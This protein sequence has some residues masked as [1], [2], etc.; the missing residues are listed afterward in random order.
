MRVVRPTLACV[1]AMIGAMALAALLPCAMVAR[2]ARAQTLNLG[3]VPDGPT[4]PEECAASTLA[5]S[6]E[7][8]VRALLA[9]ADPLQGEARAGASAR[10]KVRS[11]A[12]LLLRSGS[13]K[14]WDE[15]APAVAGARLSLLIG[16]VD[17]L[18]DAAVAGRDRR[19]DPL[20]PADARRAIALLTA[21]GAA[22]NEP[23]R[24]AM[25]APAD[26][27]PTEVARALS[28]TLAPLVELAALLEGRQN[29]DPWPVLIDARAAQPDR[30]A[31]TRSSE[32]LR[33]L[34]ASLPDGPEH[35]VLAA[36]M[37]T[38]AA[39]PS[40][41]LLAEML[42]QAAE[43]LRWLMDIRT[44]GVPFPFEQAAVEGAIARI[45]RDVQ[46]LDDPALA[47]DARTS[48]EALALTVP[49]AKAMLEFRKTDGFT[50][51]A[52]RALSDGVAALL[53]SDAG[54]ALREQE[55][56]RAAVRILE[57]CAAAE[58]LEKSLVSS[59]PKDLR[60]LLRQFDR[61]ARIAVRSLPQAFQAIAANPAD[62]VK[63]GNLSALER[64]RALESDRARIIALQGMIDAIGAV[65]PA[66]GRDFANVAKRMTRLLT[67]PLKRSDGQTAFAALESQFSGAFPFAYE[68]ELKRRTPRALELTD[69]AP[70]QVIERAAAIRAEWCEAV[71][72]GDLGG[73]ASRR[74]DLA[75]RLCQSLRDLDQIIEP[76]DRAAGD[77]LAMW[78]PW[79]MRRSMIA[80]ATQDLAARAILASRSFVA[81]NAPDTRARFER[82][83][84]A[85]ETA[86]PLVRL[87]AALERKL[88]PVLRG[89]PDTVGGQLSPL[90]TVPSSRAYLSGEWPRML[91]MHRAMIELEQARRL[92]ETKLRDALDAYLAALSRE[93]EQA[94]FGA[95]RPVVRIPG[96]DGSDSVG[97]AKEKSTEKNKKRDR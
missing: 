83:L 41:A 28:L 8:E 26:R 39:T 76:I 22:S 5:V 50:E 10:A 67:D 51:S 29:D 17:R 60:D 80:P 69:G 71:G 35:T 52:R 75:S 85:L 57:A 21:L 49:A 65:R 16:R 61:D 91:A 30:R 97:G 81:A 15:S 48:L 64:I 96:F 40:D 18:V 27:L 38:A 59:A 63:P 11:I 2:E 33:A 88:A 45:T 55:R 9:E 31:T 43:T 74:L 54:S 93:I 90:V 86:I 19:G 79:P 82:D 32:E 7:L 3:G 87:T 72:R 62:A 13:I 92:G 20:A 6:L 73:D 94:A 89:D 66:A 58:R 34:V 14:P 4:L 23:V 24:K 77:R 25:I 84:S 36:A 37:A 44:A 53:A 42:A 12:A 1:R 68:D 46:K 47:P 78:G 70:E 56:A 95:P